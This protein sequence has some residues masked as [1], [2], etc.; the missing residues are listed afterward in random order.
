LAKEIWQ[1][2]NPDGNDPAEPTIPPEVTLVSFMAK[3][4]ISI[5]SNA[6]SDASNASATPTQGTANP[7]PTRANSQPA[8]A[9][10]Q[11]NPQPSNGNDA[12]VRRRAGASNGPRCHFGELEE[13]K[14]LETKPETLSKTL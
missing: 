1:F 13:L 3:S 7:Q 5:P 4:G 10:Q 8:Q 9:N 6:S 2:A 12:A 14:T 11:A